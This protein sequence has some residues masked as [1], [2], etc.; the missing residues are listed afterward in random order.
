MIK[1]LNTLKM[2]QIM[3]TN[4]H[5]LKQKGKINKEEVLLRKR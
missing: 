3:K 5:N 2:P 4:L 1:V